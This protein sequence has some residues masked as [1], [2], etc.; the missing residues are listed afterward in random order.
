MADE[1]EM[2]GGMEVE[3]NSPPVMNGRNDSVELLSFEK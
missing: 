3:L 2:G 1:F